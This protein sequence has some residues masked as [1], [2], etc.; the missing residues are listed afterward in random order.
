MSLW[1]GLQ[2]STVILKEKTVKN[3]LKKV[4]LLVLA[5]L[6]FLSGCNR[7]G[8]PDA[9]NTQSE[10]TKV[11]IKF[12]T[13]GKD[14]FDT[15]YA[16]GRKTGVRN[17]NYYNGL[18]DNQKQNK[19]EKVKILYVMTEWNEYEAVVA[20]PQSAFIQLP[21]NSMVGGDEETN[22][23][24]K[25][26]AIRYFAIATKLFEKEVRNLKPI[27]DITDRS[28]D[29]VTFDFITNKGIYTIQ[30]KKVELEN[31]QSIWSDLF[32]ASKQLNSDVLTT[33]MTNKW[34]G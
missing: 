27:N 4:S 24:V 7:T 20:S 17:L 32:T 9:Q 6:V 31:N 28:T 1:C 2:K 34:K 25:N 13:Q 19:S 26:Y 12:A 16:D 15:I 3:D 22:R 21:S 30:E 8:A 5:S 10:A 33:Q 23:R 14:T 11:P 18:I 29:Y